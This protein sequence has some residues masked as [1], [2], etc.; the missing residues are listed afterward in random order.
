[1]STPALPPGRH[2]DLPG[3][4]RTF[5]RELP[6]PPGAPTVVLLHGWTAPSDLTWFRCYEALGHWFGVVAIDQRGHGR[7]I[8]SHHRFRLEDCADDD[9]AVIALLELG[10]GAPVIVVGYSMGGCVAQ[11]LWQRHRR[12]IDGLVLSATSGVFAES[13]QERRYFT[14]LGGLAVASRLT[15]G[16]LRRRLAHR[17]FGRRVVECELR[18]WIVDE[19]H[20]NDATTILEAGNA[21]G[22]F[23]SRGWTGGI[24]VPTAVVV[25]TA[26][27]QVD[28]ARQ[29]ALARSIPGTTVHEVDGGHDVCVSAP[30][31]FL[32][33]L[34]DACHSVATRI[35]TPVSAR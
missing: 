4:G 29:R 33:A 18:E 2:L 6:G 26:D 1:M 23:D 3:R 5:V 24:D 16:P 31:R 9:A 30:E 21:L 8:R 10:R 19:L 15:P 28:P 25:T 34:V 14:A 22:R 11:L 13:D 27:R 32:P 12:A 7:G 20:R 17:V 35:D